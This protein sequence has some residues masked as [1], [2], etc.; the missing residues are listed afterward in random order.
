MCRRVTNNDSKMGLKSGPV[1][2]AQLFKYSSVS[3]LIL[4]ATGSVCAVICGLTIPILT[5]AFGSIFDSFVEFTTSA[6]EISTNL[7]NA[8]SNVTSSYDNSSNA[9]KDFKN[10]SYI[11][12]GVT[13]SAGFINCLLSYVFMICLTKS[14]CGQG[15][16]LKKA[17]FHSLLRQEVS[18]LE[19][20]SSGSL[21]SNI[22]ADLVNIEAG[23]GEKIGFL[24][25]SLSLSA[26]SLI[27]AMIYGWKMT[28]V[29][30][31][32]APFVIA[33]STILSLFYAKSTEDE[34]LAYHDSC[35]IITEVLT[36][37]KTVYV[38]DGQ[39]KEIK[40]Y[41]D[42]LI[43]AMTLGRRRILL[44]A[45]SVAC[46]WT[47]TYIIFAI[48]IWFGVH[49]MTS[50]ESAMTGGSMFIVFWNIGAIG[51]FSGQIFPHI[52]VSYTRSSAMNLCPTARLFHRP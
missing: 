47:F 48:G 26:S 10:N 23:T 11:S 20:I 50:G 16:R 13:L 22:A 52:E 6:D 12:A 29:C 14:S 46:Y 24:L 9:V 41:E 40:R 19:D 27:V 43:P 4:L 49:E 34:S 44:T 36:L 28:L 30:L 18:Y 31:V 33:T 42:S 1:S 2:I 3:D 7:L 15:H 25:R 21:A 8:T 35:S 17:I 38:F 39:S 45:T 37:I 5:I 32:F 51:Y